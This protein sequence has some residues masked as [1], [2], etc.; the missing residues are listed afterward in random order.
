MTGKPMV[1]AILA[2]MVVAMIGIVFLQKSPE[3]FV[4]SSLLRVGSGE[5]AALE[6]QLREE[7][8]AELAANKEKRI[9]PSSIAVVKSAQQGKEGALDVAV[10]AQGGNSRSA[11][12][13]LNELL[14]RYARRKGMV[15][16]TVST[17]LEISDAERKLTAALKEKEAAIMKIESNEKEV[18]QLLI[19]EQIE[20]QQ[21]A[22]ATPQP[23][24][25]P[26]LPQLEAPATPMNPPQLTESKP[27]AVRAT[28]SLT[29]PADEEPAVDGSVLA[30]PLPRGDERR[31]LFA[32]EPPAL[33]EPEVAT[34]ANSP[35]TDEERLELNDALKY[36]KTE[37]MKLLNGGR[38]QN[39][40]AVQ[41][42]DRQIQEINRQLQ[43]KSKSAD[44]S[45]TRQVK[46]EFVSSQGK[47]S[48]RISTRQRRLKLERETAALKS[49]LEKAI[50]AEATQK[51]RLVSLVKKYETLDATFKPVI[52][53]PAKVVTT[54]QTPF[55]YGRVIGVLCG[56]LFASGLGYIFVRLTE[57]PRTLASISEAEMV[58]R[59]P[60]QTIEKPVVRRRVA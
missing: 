59:M 8:A 1:V 36:L 11:I 54:I 16:E 7:A 18:K 38:R 21:V 51:S 23:E 33:E 24:P 20:A 2:G 5:E 25:S 49:K 41:D 35:L 32:P 30:S 44:A 13:Y 53:A 27:K 46:F 56:A 60:V 50:R 58:L 42:L 28:P 47:E 39:H 15:E 40:P 55:P 31:K 19:R 4:V 43:P 9:D 17:K 3:G 14:V 22:K 6:Q 48:A 29:P 26:E 57:R 45:T 34:S 12:D 52:L 10:Q 37:R